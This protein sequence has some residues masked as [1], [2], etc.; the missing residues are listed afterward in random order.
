[1]TDSQKVEPIRRRLHCIIASGRNL[2]KT[3][4]SHPTTYVAVDRC[5]QGFRFLEHRQRSGRST[6]LA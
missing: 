1:M 5:S 2:P 4:V 3:L 6:S